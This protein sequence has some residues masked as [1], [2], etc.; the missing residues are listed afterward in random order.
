VT[1]PPFRYSAFI[2]YS[3]QDKASADWLHRTLESYRVP[4]RL[5][6]RQTAAGTVPRRL[7]P[8]FRDRDELP[9]PPAISARR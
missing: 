3:H 7:V 5:V 6:G 9:P 4:S 2:S 8:I 1:M